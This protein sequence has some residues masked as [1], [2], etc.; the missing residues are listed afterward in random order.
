[1]LRTYPG[2]LQN[3]NW[4]ARLPLLLF[5][6]R[7]HYNRN[8]QRSPFFM[9]HGFYPTIPGSIM[10]GIASV[11]VRSRSEWLREV[12]QHLP[13]SWQQAVKLLEKNEKEIKKKNEELLQAGKL[14]VYKEDDLV[15][16]FDHRSES[17]RV[18]FKEKPQ[19]RGP[20]RISK[21]ISLATY[22]IEKTNR[23]GEVRTAIVWGGHLKPATREARQRPDIREVMS[24]DGTELEINDSDDEIKEQDESEEKA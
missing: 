13:S 4:D 5:A 12:M 18:A 11:A 19:W 15:Y 22:E 17:Q 24:E 9:T 14:R 21:V 23:R 10:T 7:C 8:S 2:R 3:K 16:T 1:M 20:F 6:Y